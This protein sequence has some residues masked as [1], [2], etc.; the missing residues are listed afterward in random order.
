MA[1]ERKYALTKIAAG[2][3]LLLSNDTKTLWR[4]AKYIEGPSTGLEGW[5]RD[6][7]VWG[8]WKWETPIVLGQTAIEKDDWD[9]WEFWEGPHFSRAESIDR[10]LEMS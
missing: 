2:D 9:R 8:C 7:E 1:R 6:K 5:T 10:A 4:I 3:Y